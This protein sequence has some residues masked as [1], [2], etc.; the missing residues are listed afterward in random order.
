MNIAHA[1]KS[2]RKRAGFSSLDK[3]ARAAGY[4]RGTSIARYENAD[5]MKGR[6]LP[7]DFVARIARAIVGKGEPP[8]EASEVW[9]LAGGDVG[10][11]LT[12]VAVASIPVFAI[13]DLK[14][15][16]VDLFGLKRKASLEVADGL[17][18]WVSLE[19]SDDHCGKVCAKG[20]LVIVDVRDTVLRGGS[21]Y[22]VF[23]E[24]R[25]VVR[26]YEQNPE[27]WESEGILP[28]ATLYPRGAVEVL[29]RVVQTVVH[30]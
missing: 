2:L 16:G 18:H 22:V 14:E 13:S 11:L 20:G 21:R 5:Y 29:G 4:S 24:G 9:S 1:L 28:E 19:V 27:R 12:S 23:L 26:R 17:P 3:L 8:I 7:A 10:S 6:K 25:A 15:G 30:W